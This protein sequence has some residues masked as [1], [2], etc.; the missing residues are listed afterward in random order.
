MS[1][2]AAVTYANSANAGSIRRMKTRTTPISETKTAALVRVLSAVTHG[3]TRLCTGSVSPQRLSSLVSKFDSL[4]GI[5]NTKAQRVVNKRAGRANTLFAAYSP[6]EQYLAKDEKLPWILLA[7]EGDGLEAEQLRHVLD[8]P[9]WLDYQLCRHND[10]GE[11][12]WTWRRT[13]TEM[14]QLYAELSEH[15]AQQRHGEI[16]RMLDRISHQPGFHGVRA[17]AMRLFSFAV[18]RGYRGPIP[19]LFFVQKIAHGRPLAII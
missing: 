9:V 16:G 3:Y 11:V 5:A 17:Q 19:H 14:T 12:R 18:S 8:R 10:M 7:T 13:H 6:P 15:L 2:P 4:Y 1:A